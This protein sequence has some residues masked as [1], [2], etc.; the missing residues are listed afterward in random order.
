[1]FL[2]FFLFFIKVVFDLRP[3]V[4]CYT[5]SRYLQNG[6]KLF[7]PKT[8]P[9]SRSYTQTFPHFQRWTKSRNGH[10]H[11]FK[12]WPKSE[13][14]SSLVFHTVPLCGIL[15][16]IKFWK[17]DKIKECF[18]TSKKKDKI[19]K[20][21]Y[22]FYTATFPHLQKWA[23]SRNVESSL[24]M[25]KRLFIETFPHFQKMTKIRVLTKIRVSI[26]V[27]L[28]HCPTVWNTNDVI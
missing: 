6:N 15:T 14:L 25:W 26:I 4:A 27:C 18:H 21:G 17:L 7:R 5:K 9:P 28:P 19:K 20:C 12:K 11:T 8:I 1:M 10:F 3:Q 13:Y 24:E 16:T 22:V 23:K 2:I